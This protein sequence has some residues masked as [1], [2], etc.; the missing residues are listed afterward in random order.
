[1]IIMKVKME[2]RFKEWTYKDY[3]DFVYGVV[4]GVNAIFVMM[5]CMIATKD[6][7]PMPLFIFFS[8]ITLYLFWI[9]DNIINSRKSPINK[10][11][12]SNKKD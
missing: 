9:F 4:I 5:S 8:V 7:P 2:K 6:Y 1:M 11:L 12:S 10:D 3:F